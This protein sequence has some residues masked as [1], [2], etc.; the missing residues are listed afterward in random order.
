[1]IVQ[2][3]QA[4]YFEGVRSDSVE[5]PSF[6]GKL[7]PAKVADIVRFICLTLGLALLWAC[8]GDPKQQQL[9]Y[10]ES[11]KEYFEAGDYEYAV[12]QFRNAAEAIPGVSE[13]HYQLGRTYLAL[14]RFEAAYS[15]LTNAVSLDA[16]HSEAQLQ[17]AR[18][19]I[20]RG[21]HDE[22]QR[23]AETVVESNPDS[24]EAHAIL[25][26]N[27][28]ATRDLPEA[29]VELRKSVDINPERVQDYAALGAVHR[30]AG[31]PVEAEAVYEEAVAVNQTS[32]QARL[33][34]GQFY[35]SQ[36]RLSEAEEQIRA[37]GGLDPQAVQPRLF[38]AEIQQAN[39]NMLDAEKT[40]AELKTVA[41]EDPQAVQ[42]LAM[43]YRS[44]GQREK[45]VAELESL[46][47]G[48]TDDVAV[49]RYL[50]EVLID[51]GRIAEAESLNGQVLRADPADA[52]GLLA[53]ARIQISQQLYK[54]AI[55]T[56]E[57]SAISGGESAQRHYL[58]G[59]AQR[60]I[61]QLQLA[62]ASFTRAL[63]L[64]PELREAA[65]ELSQLEVLSGDHDAALR[66]NTDVP[67]ED[68]S[69]P[70]VTTV[71]ARAAL[72]KNDALA[73]EALLEDALSAD[74]AY[75]PALSSL[76]ALRA[77]Q[78]RALE[79]VSRIDGLLERYPQ[80][81]GL[82]FLLAVGQ[83][84]LN[85][86]A[87][88]RASALRATSL[89]PE[90]PSVHTL[91]ANIE[92]ANGSIENAKGYFR[93]AIQLNPRSVTNYMALKELYEKEGD[94]QEVGLL[95]EK[96][97][98]V[99]PDSPR[100]ANDLAYHYL[101]HGGDVNSAVTLAQSV[102]RRMPN[103]PVAADTLGWAY[104]KAGLYEPALAPLSKSVE[105]APNNPLYRYHLGMAR[106]EANQIEAA[107]SSLGKA[108]EQGLDSRYATS[109][110]A[111]LD[112]ISQ[113]R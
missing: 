92:L 44:T 79:T 15:E 60:A 104:Y 93:K 62:K 90:S 102:V 99:D 110:R 35:L 112:E 53:E 84:S 41:P 85:N 67:R 111:T 68:P 66:L 7:A 91:L 45:A 27:H 1:M 55:G 25:G 17:L 98:E 89:D 14:G 46:L 108:I 34:L 12:V 78:G 81:A 33:A 21:E 39:G 5:S 50:V 82:Q 109:A 77:D 52:E 56:L 106:A 59:G 22:A 100:L 96:A 37:S 13:A 42:A 49:K 38:L 43:F 31:Q 113:A 75:L 3:S 16:N 97:L 65:L 80:N 19:Q 20:A 47:A 51:L 73:G 30:A 26:A 8:A 40:Y 18:L 63:E 58:L 76:L 32:V 69:F 95:Y 28:F 61:G 71:K 9:A 94:W 6:A 64:D 10:I 2:R 24:A 36:G 87:E 72:A 57:R 11:G 29:I 107:R 54:E 70:S 101:E 48:T 88:S 86:L 103:S 74:P 23:L 83:F 4:F 105:L